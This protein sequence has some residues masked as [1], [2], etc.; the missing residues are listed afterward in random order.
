MSKT[1]QEK[2]TFLVHLGKL[3]EAAGYGGMLT[4]MLSLIRPCFPD[5]QPVC[6]DFKVFLFLHFL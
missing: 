5:I 2:T 1:L 6:A 3:L 4:A